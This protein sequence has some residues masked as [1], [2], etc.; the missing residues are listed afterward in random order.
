MAEFI[1][2]SLGAAFLVLFAASFNK[3]FAHRYLGHHWPREAW[4]F[5]GCSMTSRCRVCSARI[6]MDS[7]GNWFAFSR[8]FDEDPTP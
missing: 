2:C 4:G 3:R 1:G 6:G 5:D 7:Q 8:Q